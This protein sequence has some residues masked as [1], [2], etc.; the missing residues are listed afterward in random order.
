MWLIAAVQS[1]D[2]LSSVAASTAL[3]S[4]LVA[5]VVGKDRRSRPTDHGKQTIAAAEVPPGH[6]CGDPDARS[7][8][9]PDHPSKHSIA[10][11]NTTT[12]TSP[13]TRSVPL[14]SL[15]SNYPTLNGEDSLATRPH[16]LRE[17]SAKVTGRSLFDW[18]LP[19][20]PRLAAAETST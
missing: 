5:V 12:S 1:I 18:F 17:R 14:A 15:I 11:R 4:F 7:R 3:T 10:V 20:R 13:A 19:S 2:P 9:Q 8:G 16:S 6:S